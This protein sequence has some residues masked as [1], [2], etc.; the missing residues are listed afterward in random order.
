MVD[1]QARCQSVA[2]HITIV[3]KLKQ[4]N[5]LEGHILTEPAEEGNGN[6]SFVKEK[7][8]GTFLCK[9]LTRK[10]P[11]HCKVIIDSPTVV[12]AVLQHR[13]HL[14]TFH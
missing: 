10:R 1:R 12:A 6:I 13:T 9:M 4:G 11:Q 8:R 5:H 3:K 2:K 7:G 14:S